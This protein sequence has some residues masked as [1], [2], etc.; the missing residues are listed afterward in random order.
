MHE[1]SM[2]LCASFV[3]E[4]LDDRE[5]LSIGEIGSYDVNGTYSNLFGGPKGWTYTG[6]DIREGPNVDVVL[7]ADWAECSVNLPT[8]D[9]I[10]CG[11]VLEH[12]RNPFILMDGI[13]SLLQMGGLVWV[14]AP[15]HWPFHEHP[16]DCFRFWPDGLRSVM[17]DAG[18]AV[19]ECE[20]KGWDTY[21]VGKKK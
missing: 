20:A 12:V 1:N 5:E 17:E 10:I 8:H 2:E 9:V 13:A 15:N 6:Y 11:Q 19:I 21:A 7:E 14:C 4:Y 16:I 3:M 18:L